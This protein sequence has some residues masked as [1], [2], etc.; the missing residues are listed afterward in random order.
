MSVH[1]LGWQACVDLLVLIRCWAENPPAAP[2]TKYGYWWCRCV[3]ELRHWNRPS[4]KGRLPHLPASCASL[5]WL[6]SWDRDWCGISCQPFQSLESNWKIQRTRSLWDCWAPDIHSSRLYSRED[7]EAM[8]ESHLSRD[9]PK[10][11]DSSDLAPPRSTAKFD[12]AASSQLQPNYNSVFRDK[13]RWWAGFSL[14]LRIYRRKTQRTI[15]P[16]WFACRWVWLC[17]LLWWKE[18]HLDP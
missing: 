13:L 5:L 8:A 11:W 18:V 17:C 6:G 2:R 15:S 4:F 3:Q 12:P 9:S 7:R 1:S 16:S 10:S 14:P